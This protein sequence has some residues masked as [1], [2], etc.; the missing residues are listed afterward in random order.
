MALIDDLAAQVHANTDVIA[1]ANT[2]I[3]GFAQRLD[4]ATASE[5]G[6][7]QLQ[8]VPPEPGSGETPLANASE[9]GAWQLRLVS[10][11]S[12]PGSGETPLAN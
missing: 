8:L 7:W 5:P 3:Q 1:S 10:P 11:E 4:D 6:A 2:L 9:P 12:Q